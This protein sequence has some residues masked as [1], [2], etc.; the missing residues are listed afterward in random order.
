MKKEGSK[1]PSNL[2]IIQTLV[3]DYY[4]EFSDEEE[5]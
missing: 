1:L 5:N 2:D 3:S 4:D